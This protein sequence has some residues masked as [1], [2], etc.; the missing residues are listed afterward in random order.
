MR[1]SQTLTVPTAAP[2]SFTTLSDDGI[3]VSVDGSYVINNWTDHAPT[4]DL[5]NQVLAV[6]DH[7]LVVEYY[8]QGG[9]AVAQFSYASSSRVPAGQWLAQY[10]DGTALAGPVVG[11]RCEAEINND[12]GG[13]APAGIAVGPDNFSVRWTQT[14][15]VP[16]AAPYSFTTQSDDGIRVSVDGSDVINNWTD[17][18]PTT[19][20]GGQAL[21]VGD[22][23]LVVEYYERG[24]GAVAQFS[25]APSPRVRPANGWPSTTT[26]QHWRTRSS[27]PAARRK[28]HQRLGSGGPDWDRGRG[29]QLLGALVS[30]PERADR[31]PVLL[32]HP[33]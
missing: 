25:Y 21:A 14:L 32:H 33:Q 26:E 6:G 15:T 17:H 1:W 20:L 24:G 4:T 7:P 19:D 5:G 18:G 3:R 31:G 2:Y 23:P 13:G 12:W 28:H 9:G 11:A 16:T 29:G 10:Y 30:D 8:E 22:H 27:V